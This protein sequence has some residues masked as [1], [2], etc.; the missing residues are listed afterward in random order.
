MINSEAVVYNIMIEILLLYR[1][2]K[3]GYVQII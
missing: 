2:I 1:N 3:L